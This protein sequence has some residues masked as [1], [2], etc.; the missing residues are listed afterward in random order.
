MTCGEGDFETVYMAISRGSCFSVAGEYFHIQSNLWITMVL[1]FGEM[2]GPLVLI[3]QWHSCN[4][5][6]LNLLQNFIAFDKVTPENVGDAAERALVKVFA[7]T[8]LTVMGDTCFKAVDKSDKK[9]DPDDLIF[10]LLFRLLF[11]QTCICN[12]P[13]ELSAS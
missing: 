9:H 4:A 5:V 13:S 8:Y 1:N 6:D 12:Q 7:E 3:F 11:F 10:M 2:S